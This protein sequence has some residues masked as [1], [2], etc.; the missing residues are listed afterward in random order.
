MCVSFNAPSN[1]LNE[2]T[3]SKMHCQIWWFDCWCCHRRLNSEWKGGQSKWQ[4]QHIHMAKRK[5]HTW[6]RTMGR[7]MK[8]MTTWKSF[9]LHTKICKFFVSFM[10]VKLNVMEIK[11]WKYCVN[12][13]DQF[14][15]CFNRDG[16][17]TIV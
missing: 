1:A 12:I 10:K 7:E 11:I 2:Q 9:L 14:N 17:G 15:C 13:A 5:A 8:Q 3:C 6:T 16:Q 4:C